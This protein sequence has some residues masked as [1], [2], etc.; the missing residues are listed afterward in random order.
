[1]LPPVE[2]DL[3]YEDE[4]WTLT[5]TVTL[6]L[7][8]NPRTHPNPNP[9]FNRNGN[10]VFERKPKRQKRHQNVGQHRLTFLGQFAGQGVGVRKAPYPPAQSEDQLTILMFGTQYISD[11]LVNRGN[12]RRYKRDPES[13]TGVWVG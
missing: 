3:G 10:K 4:P 9:I 8:P 12:N 5:L 11:E 7:N 13:K 1:M 2:Y 6:T